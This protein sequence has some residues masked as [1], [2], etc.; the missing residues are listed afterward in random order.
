MK[1]KSPTNELFGKKPL[2][3]IAQTRVPKSDVA[4]NNGEQSV[5]MYS[6]DSRVFGRQS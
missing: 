2:Y 1:N 5:V 3:E 6:E 4:V